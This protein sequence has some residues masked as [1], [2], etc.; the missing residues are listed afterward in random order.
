MKVGTEVS[1]RYR[2]PGSAFHPDCWEPPHKGVVLAINDPRP[3]SNTLAFPGRTPT[4]EEVDAHLANLAERG[5]SITKTPVLY[6][7]G[8]MWDTDVQPY[9]DVLAEW[10]AARQKKYEDTH[11]RVTELL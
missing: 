8:V 1:T 7:F 4:V 11:E 3:W 2:W 10:Q 9:E 5:L 6:S